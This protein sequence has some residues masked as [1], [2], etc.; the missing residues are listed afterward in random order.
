M[1]LIRTAYGV[2]NAPKFVRRYCLACWKWYLATKDVHEFEI[3]ADCLDKKQ[4][5]PN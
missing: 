3:C 1:K 4:K 5:A 2:M